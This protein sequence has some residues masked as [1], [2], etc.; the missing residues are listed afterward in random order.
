M[1]SPHDQIWRY[2][3][4]ELSKEEKLTF[5]RALETDE[6][7]RQALLERKVTD[8]LLHEAATEDNNESLIDIL[9]EKWEAEHPAFKEGPTLSRGK[10]IKL[11]I[12]LATAAAAA[13]VLFSA[14]WRTGTIHW[15]KTIYGDGPQVRGETGTKATYSRPDLRRIAKMLRHTIEAEITGLSARNQKW[16]LQLH[17]Q[18]VSGG[19]LLVEITGHPESGFGV[20]KVWKTD[21]QSLEVLQEKAY[22]LAQKIA[23]D[24]SEPRAP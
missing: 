4:N 13:F 24:L 5:E 10:M 15:Q 14:P 11:G 3:H 1:K 18:E 19:N 6:L 21:F 22:D 12:P 17:L 16:N 7:L 23:A 9:L 2:L 8:K 20:S